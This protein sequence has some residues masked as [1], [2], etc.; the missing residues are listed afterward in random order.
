VSTSLDFEFLVVDL[1]SHL[2]R[3]FVTGRCS[4]GTP[5]VGNSFHTVF[6]EDVIKTPEGGLESSAPY[7]RRTVELRIVSIEAYARLLDFISEGHAARI[8]LEGSGLD[9]LRKYDLSGSYDIIS[10]LSEPKITV[11]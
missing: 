8:E 10:S 2:G 4:K 9:L 7:D 3:F 1:A 6:R 11:S 5:R